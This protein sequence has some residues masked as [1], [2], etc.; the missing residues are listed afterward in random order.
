MLRECLKCGSE[1]DA[2]KR[3]VNRGNGKFCSL[4]CANSFNR[5][6]NHP[7]NVSCTLCGK[8]FYKCPSKM[9]NSK[10]GLYFCS[11]SCKDKAQRIGGVVAI[12][13]SHYG[14]C[15]SNYRVT[16]FRNMPKVCSI[17]SY[18]AYEEALE[19]HHIDK[20]RTNNEITN[21]KVLC[22]NCHRLVHIGKIGIGGE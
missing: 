11:R 14:S 2:P 4:S 16:A 15:H 5:K 19:V 9:R 17:C 12:Q 18:D 10:S 13:P 1:F 6:K 20:D 22:R 21:L 3:E 7:P 8:K